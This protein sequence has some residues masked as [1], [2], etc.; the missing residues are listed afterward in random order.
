MTFRELR[1]SVGLDQPQLAFRSG[2]H[3]TTISQIECG[4]VRDPR[5][6]TVQALADALGTT[7][8]VVVRAIEQTEVSA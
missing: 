2:V 7:A 4:R 6:S 5:Y 8:A 3:Q 1:E